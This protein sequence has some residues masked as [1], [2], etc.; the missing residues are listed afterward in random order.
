MMERRTFLTMVAGGLLAAPL[1]AEAQQILEP[2]HSPT[3][4]AKLVAPDADVRYE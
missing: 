3:L 1:A 4:D 2:E